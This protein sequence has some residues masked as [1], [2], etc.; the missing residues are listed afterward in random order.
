MGNSISTYFS[1]LRN[2]Y[3]QRFVL[4]TLGNIRTGKVKVI[5]ATDDDDD[6]GGKKQSSYCFG[7]E[8][9]EGDLETTLVVKDERFWWRLCSNLD[10]VSF[11]FFC[12]LF[13]QKP[14]A[15]SYFCGYSS[16]I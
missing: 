16:Y 6:G 2:S 13:F 7:G 8:G 10:L 9:V 1:A 12:F 15:K 3:A 4:R 14:L 11:S 5:V